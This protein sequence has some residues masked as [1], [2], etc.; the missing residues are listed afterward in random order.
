MDYFTDKFPT[1]IEAAVNK[2][3]EDMPF[4][5][6]TWIAN[7]NE[8]KLIAFHASYGI[9]L[10]NEFRLW[11]NGPLLQSCREMAGMKEIDANQA[12]YVILKETQRRLLQSTSVLKVVK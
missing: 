4:K 8:E 1:T 7:L 6:R 11:G 12:S 9:F 5:D 2:L 3:I 10:R